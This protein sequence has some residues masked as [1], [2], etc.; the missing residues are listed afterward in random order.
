MKQT[1]SPR[2]SG[3]RGRTR[4]KFAKK[5][6]KASVNDLL[7][8][9]ELGDRVQVTVDGSIH[10]GL[11]D[12]SFKGLCGEIVGKRGEGYEISIMKGNQKQL[13]VTTPVHIKKV[14][15]AKAVVAEKAN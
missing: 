13:L 9:F 5:G 14:G 7:A 4:Y 11:P 1:G 3:K 8:E 15:E 6:P 2:K 10:S 12:K